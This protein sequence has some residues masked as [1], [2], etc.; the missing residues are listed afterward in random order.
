MPSDRSD[1]LTGILLAALIAAVWLASLL[2]ALQQPLQQM[3]LA[4]LM[5]NQFT[6]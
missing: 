1:P 6:L 5:G 3:G 4:E 2:V